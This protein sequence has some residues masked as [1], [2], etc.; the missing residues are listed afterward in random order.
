MPFIVQHTAEGT[1]L[2]TPLLDLNYG[3]PNLQLKFE[4]PIRMG[5]MSAEF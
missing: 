4:I 1:E 3:L 2:D 5:S